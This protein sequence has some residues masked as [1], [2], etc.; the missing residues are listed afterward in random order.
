[1]ELYSS[2]RTMSERDKEM[3]G[4]EHGHLGP[5]PFCQGNHP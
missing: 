3:N 4:A 5:F 2:D 1:M